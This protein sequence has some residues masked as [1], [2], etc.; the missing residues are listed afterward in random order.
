MALPL[1]FRST[2]RP[3]QPV[4]AWPAR[5]TIPPPPSGRSCPSPLSPRKL[6]SERIDAQFAKDPPGPI[7]LGARQSADLETPGI[8]EQS[9]GRVACSSEPLPGLFFCHRLILL[10]LQLTQSLHRVLRCRK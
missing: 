1:L 7:L 5:H 9:V 3:P 8:I 2:L 10:S 4:V 6:D